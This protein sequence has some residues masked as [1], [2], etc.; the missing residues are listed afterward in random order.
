MTTKLSLTFYI[1]FNQLDNKLLSNG[2]LLLRMST[3]LFIYLFLVNHF[4]FEKSMNYQQSPNFFNL[5]FHNEIGNQQVNGQHGIGHHQ[6]DGSKLIAKYPFIISKPFELQ[7]KNF[8][9]IQRVLLKETFMIE[10]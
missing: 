3:V 6:M 10:I 1:N 7:K 4:R 8:R 5:F 2:K 9:I